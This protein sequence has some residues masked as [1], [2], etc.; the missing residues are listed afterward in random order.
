MSDYLGPQDITFEDFS[1]HITKSLV[2]AVDP[3]GLADVPSKKNDFVW[4]SAGLQDALQD[5]YK[6][7]HESKLCWD[8][9][10]GIDQ[11]SVFDKIRGSLTYNENFTDWKNDT[12][13]VLAEQYKVLLFSN[14]MNKRH[15]KRWWQLF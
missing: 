11:Q 13:R 8:K 2:L 6:K 5:I 7:A 1:N 4:Q 3:K 15:Q 9:L 12:E 10:S 14:R